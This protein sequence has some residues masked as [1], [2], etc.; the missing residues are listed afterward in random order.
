MEPLELASFA[1]RHVAL[2]TLFKHFSK[3]SEAE[4]KALMRSAPGAG[5]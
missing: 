4:Y 1:G 5:A 3:D 2:V